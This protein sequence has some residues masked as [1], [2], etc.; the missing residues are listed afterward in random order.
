MIG[1]SGSFEDQYNLVKDVID[2]KKSE[3]ENIGEEL[4]IAEERL[5]MEEVDEECFDTVAPTVQEREARDRSEDIPVEVDNEDL[6]T[7]YDFG[8]DIGLRESTERGTD[9]AEELIRNKVSDQEYRS[10]VQS[11][12]RK[13]KEIFYHVLKHVKTSS[14]Q[15]FIFLSGGAGVGK[16]RVTKTIHQALIRHYNTVPGANPEC[17]HVLLAAPTGKAAYLMG[18]FTIHTAFKVPPIDF[19]T[20]KPLRSDTLNSL[21]KK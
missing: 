4:D 10:D 8:P 14:E 18:G 16:T 9:I 7:D 15:F 20:Y 5:Q 1:N 21:R 12:N 6:F 2:I 11:L 19:L 17:L 13:Q 3:Y